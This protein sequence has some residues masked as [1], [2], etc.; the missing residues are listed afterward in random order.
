MPEPA[1]AAWYAY[2]S[3]SYNA[4]S[5]TP[6]FSEDQVSGAVIHYGDVCN[7]GIYCDGSN[8]GNRSLWDATQVFTD[9]AGY[10]TYTWTDQRADASGQYDAA[11]SDAQK[12]Q[13]QWD[14]VYTA[15]Q[16]GGTPLL[17]SAAGPAACATT[18]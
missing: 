16:T 11:Q 9:L 4:S 10:V 15:C 14:Q 3:V 13:A 5:S 1:S 6:A 8:T 12:L 17:K 7:L 2:V 18:H